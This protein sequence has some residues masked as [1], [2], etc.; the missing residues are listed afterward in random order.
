MDV[1][2]PDPQRERLPWWVAIPGFVILLW[3]APFLAT[4]GIGAALRLVWWWW[5]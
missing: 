2:R 5:P 3:V 4:L 1:W